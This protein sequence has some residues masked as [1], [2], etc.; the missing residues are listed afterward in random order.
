MDSYLDRKSKVSSS[1]Q[2]NGVIPKDRVK[3]KTSS[4]R[5]K[6]IFI[7][8][9]SP[10]PK[11]TPPQVS[12]KKPIFVF[13]K[14]PEDLPLKKKKNVT[15]WDEKPNFDLKGS[16]T[17][18][19][20]ASK[21]IH[22]NPEIERPA[23]SSDRM[24]V[25]YDDYLENMRFIDD[26][27]LSEAKDFKRHIDNELFGTLKNEAP[28]T[29]VD[30]TV[31]NGAEICT[32]CGVVTDA[33]VSLD[34]KDSR[35][36]GISDNRNS[37]DPSRCHKRKSI[38]RSIHKDVEGMQFPESIIEEASRR[39]QEIIGNDIY[40]G[41]K[42]KSIIVACIYFTYLD[43]HEFKTVKDL[44]AKFKLTRKNVK[45]GFS[46]YCEKFEA[47]ATK[48]VEPKDLIY[49]IMLN[50]GINFTHLRKIRRLCE[51]LDN[52]SA[53]L[54]RSNP[55]SVAAA[56]VYL[57]LCLEP[58]YKAKLGMTKMKFANLVNLSDITI[59]KLGKEAQRIIQNN[60]IRL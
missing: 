55:Q 56:I 17:S 22:Q 42:R 50:V 39:Y 7:F 12:K 59:T 32:N 57:Y 6:P 45:E 40:R 37:K 47:A 33:S 26:F 27:S 38:Q 10:V 2:A 25:Q 9:E 18:R 3:A 1:T 19:N 41:S 23:G 52:R 20:D 44:I 11:R 5:L 21:D 4:T 49:H 13:E 8:V 24:A 14:D 16:T 36:Y 46:K 60:E 31:I 48:Y 29:H 43:Q 58:E 54:N 34:D 15:F 28:C 35:Y 30:R 51:Y 53:L